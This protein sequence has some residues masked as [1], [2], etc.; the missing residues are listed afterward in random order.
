VLE[1]YLLLSPGV[2]DRFLATSLFQLRGAGD[3]DNPLVERI[4]ASLG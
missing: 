1:D 3:R 2:R 4:R